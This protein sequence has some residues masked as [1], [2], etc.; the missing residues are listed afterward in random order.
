MIFS[1][2]G[3][4]LKSD[5]ML[6]GAESQ[7]LRGYCASVYFEPSRDLDDFGTLLLQEQLSSIERDFDSRVE[8]YLK[9][10]DPTL[11]NGDDTSRRAVQQVCD[12]LYQMRWGPTRIPVY[13]LLGQF[14]SIEPEGKSRFLDIAH[15]FIK[16]GVPVDGKDVSG[17]TG[18][19]H[20]LSI[21]PTFDLEYAQVLFDAGGEVNNRNRHGSN[22]AHEIVQ[23]LAD[24][25]Q[26]KEIAIESFQW[27]LSHG[28][29]VDVADSDGM[30]VRDL[31]ESIGFF[32][33]R[34]MKAIEKEDQRRAAL[35][36]PYCA[37][38]GMRN[39]KLL[40]C[41]RCMKAKYCPRGHKQC[42]KL[43]WPHHKRS[44]NK[45]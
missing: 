41:S 12:D 18:L 9:S 28:G 19:A 8:S 22:A 29:N 32:M 40:T 37:F 43:D 44:C 31:C 39:P 10:S 2:L 38:C 24:N 6:R 3:E 15:F 33:P 27:F 35:E 16:K 20:S 1:V 26:S 5:E 17:T 7:R 45:A 14:R 23:L 34:F 13:S 21:K 25:L 30:V 11:G 4:L 36:E 42:Q